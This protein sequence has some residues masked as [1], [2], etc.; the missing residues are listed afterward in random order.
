MDSMT[1][2]ERVQIVA[3]VLH[4]RGVEPDGET[5][6]SHPPAFWERLYEEAGTALRNAGASNAEIKMYLQAYAYRL[7]SDPTMANDQIEHLID[8][9]SVGLGVSLG[10]RLHVAA[11]RE[12]IARGQL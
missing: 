9:A 10:P 1:D 4:K 11:A 3:R 12:W 8:A 6:L 7:C 5:D 2:T